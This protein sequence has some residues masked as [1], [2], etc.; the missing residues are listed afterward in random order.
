MPIPAY[1][2]QEKGGGC[3]RKTQYKQPRGAAIHRHQ[4]TPATQEPDELSDA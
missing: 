3:R 2:S 1:M 4:L